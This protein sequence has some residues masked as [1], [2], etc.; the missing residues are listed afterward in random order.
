MLIGMRL[1]LLREQKGLSQGA[2]EEKT[3][4]MRCYLSRIENGHTVPSLETLERIASALEVPLYQVFRPS[5]GEA[6]PLKLSRRKSL[7]ELA[8]QE[9]KNG[10]D[11][12]FLL[13]LKAMW[14]RMTEP[15]RDILLS[16]AKKMAA[17]T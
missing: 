10:E 15:D 11:A 7:E 16:L 14:T 12:R 17:R 4:L 2:I 6:L 9:G 13:H 1:R 3:G 5:E 8:E